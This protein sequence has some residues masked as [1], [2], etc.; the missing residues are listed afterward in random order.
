MMRAQPIECGLHHS[1]IIF[2]QKLMI[3][4]LAYQNNSLLHKDIA[5]ASSIS[6]Q[7]HS[8]SFCK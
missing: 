6:V 8:I 7:P 2:E 5:N 1:P 3:S 4:L